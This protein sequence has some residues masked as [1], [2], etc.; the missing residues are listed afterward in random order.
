MTKHN[1]EKMI[2]LNHIIVIT[3]HFPSLCLHAARRVWSLAVERFG[4]VD[5]T[6]AWSIVDNVQVRFY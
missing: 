3:P 4:D 1:S 2:I 6:V 5:K